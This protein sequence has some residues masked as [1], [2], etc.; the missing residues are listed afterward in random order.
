MRKAPTY[1][2]YLKKKS[3]TKIKR[4]LAKS[5]NALLEILN[6]L[7]VNNESDEDTDD[8]KD[9]KG[10]LKKIRSLRKKYDQ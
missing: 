2:E 10:Y 7:R 9:L 6:V 3:I 4:E 1:D 8:Q 5:E